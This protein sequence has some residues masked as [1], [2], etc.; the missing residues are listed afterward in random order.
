MICA[1]CGGL[2]GNVSLSSQLN[3]LTVFLHKPASGFTDLDPHRVPG[4]K[5][6]AFWFF[7]AE[8]LQNRRLKMGMNGDFNMYSH[9]VETKVSYQI[10]RWL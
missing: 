8:R 7:F 6:D 1:L 2:S 10:L 5:T 9:Y 3:C 4:V